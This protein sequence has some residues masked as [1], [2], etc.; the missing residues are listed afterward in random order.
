M[1][2]STERFL[3]LM[4]RQN[5]VVAAQTAAREQQTAVKADQVRLQREQERREKWGQLRA[6]EKPGKRNHQVSRVFPHI[7]LS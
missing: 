7:D 5:A 6:R 3:F 2:K 1:D 4:E